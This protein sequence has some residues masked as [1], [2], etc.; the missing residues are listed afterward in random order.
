MSTMDDPSTKAAG[1]RYLPFG[2][3]VYFFNATAEQNLMKLDRKQDLNV[4]LQVC[5]FHADQKNKLKM[6]FDRLRHFR[7]LLCNCKM[8][9]KEKKQDLNLLYQ[10]CVFLADQN[11]TMSALASDWLR[12]F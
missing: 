11:T 6:A 2:P 7:L 3:L 5:V 12:Q 1:A 8:E 10:V 9:F 4:L